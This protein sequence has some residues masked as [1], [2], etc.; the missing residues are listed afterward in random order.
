VISSLAI[1][2]SVPAILGQRSE[3][4]LGLI[5]SRTTD[6]P[7]NNPTVIQIQ[8]VN[9]FRDSDGYYHVQGEITNMGNNTIADVLVTA[10]FYNSY[11]QL[12]G[13]ANHYTAPPNLE[14]Q[15]TGTFDVLTNQINGLPAFVRLSY[16][17]D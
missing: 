14:S 16:D 7:N 8:V 4:V 17:W 2:G 1:I 15:H 6:Y 12:V 10:H 11:S 3:L 13:D 9:I 5:Q